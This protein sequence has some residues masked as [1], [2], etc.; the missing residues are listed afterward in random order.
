M[1][2]YGNPEKVVKEGNECRSKT[3]LCMYKYKCKYIHGFPFGT[4]IHLEEKEETENRKHRVQWLD[5]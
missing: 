5:N 2:F 1:E 3:R 4:L